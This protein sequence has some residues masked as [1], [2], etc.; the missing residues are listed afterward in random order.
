MNKGPKYQFVLITIVVISLILRLG[1]VLVN[2][3]ANDNHVEVVRMIMKTHQLPIMY[4]CREC[5]HP[6]LFYVT[7]AMLLQ[8]FSITTLTNQIVF[9]QLLNFIA[10][11][12][13]LAVVYKFIKEYSS[14]DGTLKLIVFTL[15]VLNP[16]LIAINSQAS[17]DTFVILFSTLALYFTDRF[18]KKPAPGLFAVI[19]LF[20][21]LAVSTKVTGLIV[22]AAIFL[23]FLLASWAWDEKKGSMAAYGLILLATVILLTVLNPLSQVVTNYQNFGSPFAN[24]R[25]KLPLPVIFQKTYKYKK[26]QFRPG[27]VSI[28]DGFF[29]FKFNDLLKFPLITNEV[30]D[31]PPHRTSF[32]TMLY[33]DAHSLHFQ[34]WPPSWL[35]T[36]IFFAGFLRELFDFLKA[37]FKRDKPKIRSLSNGLFLLTFGGNIAFLMLSALLFRDFAFIKLAYILPGLLA[38]TWLFLRGA[39]MVFG[40]VSARTRLG[41]QLMIGWMVTLLGFYIWDVLTM[42]FHLYSTNIRVG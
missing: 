11:A 13:T 18:F 7:A 23:S 31:F 35:P 29:T 19:I 28:Q 20:L 39:E 6:K 42:I 36:L 4:E 3:E 32:W 17:N 15:V 21:L 34:N 30:D 26:Y 10:G 2:R 12:I 33:A 16:K 8:G 40:Q 25:G 38:F 27:I 22:F 41:L 24:T 5:F 9:I 1:L 14:Q 37:L